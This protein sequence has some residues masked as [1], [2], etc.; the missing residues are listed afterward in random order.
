MRLDRRAPRSDVVTVLAIWAQ[1][2]ATLYLTGLIWVIQVVHYPLMDHVSEDGFVA[3]HTEH[4]RRISAVVIVPMLVELITA[5]ALVV[6]RPPGVSVT[7]LAAGLAL[8][9]VI[10][11]STFGVQVPLHRHLSDGLDPAAHRALVRG[12]WIRTLAWT[13]RA[14]VVIA[15]AVTAAG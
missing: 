1:L 3:F 2:A 9:A 14:V 5:I 15:I 7:L 10:W 12:N 8:V 4:A 11:L 13:L 6:V